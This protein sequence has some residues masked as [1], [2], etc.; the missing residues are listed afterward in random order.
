MN[1]FAIVNTHRSQFT[2]EMRNR[3]HQR[4]PTNRQFRKHVYIQQ[5]KQI[6]ILNAG[7]MIHFVLESILFVE[8]QAKNLRGRKKT[9]QTKQH[10]VID[11]YFN[12]P[13]CVVLLVLLVLRFI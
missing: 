12:R 10:D 1:V 13:N 11:F 9:T 5:Q 2:L 3:L 6:N 8:Q 7:L 4:R